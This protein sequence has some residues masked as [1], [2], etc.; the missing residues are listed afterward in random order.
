MDALEKEEEML[1]KAREMELNNISD[2]EIL[3][4]EE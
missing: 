3:D 4:E 2:E 1:E